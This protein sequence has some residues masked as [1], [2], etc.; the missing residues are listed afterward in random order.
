MLLVSTLGIFI[1]LLPSL[2]GWDLSG[3]QVPLR[4]RQVSVQAPE[5]EA[6]GARSW[7][8]PDSSGRAARS[9]LAARADLIIFQSST[10]SI[11]LSSC[12]SARLT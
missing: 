10:E 8:Q 5:F 9:R 3:P 2:L 1:P 11:D 7:K 12:F 4:K 6:A